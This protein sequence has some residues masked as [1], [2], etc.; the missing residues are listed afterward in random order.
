MSS[1]DA[2]TRVV[3]R[4]K[5]RVGI[6][7]MP[8]VAHIRSAGQFSDEVTPEIRRQ[9]SAQHGVLINDETFCSLP[10][11]LREE[12]HAFHDVVWKTF[13]P[14]LSGI[15]KANRARELAA[16]AER[17]RDRPSRWWP[18]A[19]EFREVAVRDDGSLWN[20]NGYADADVR[21]A[22][23]KAE[24]RLAE[25]KQ[26]S[27]QRG[28]EKRAK[29]REQRI[30]AAAEAIRKGAGIGHRLNCYCCRKALTDPASI[31]RGIGPECWEHV[32]KAVEGRL[33]EDL[34]HA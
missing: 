17:T 18:Q 11:A 20:P 28:V 10:E 16:Q 2:G 12:F 19:G 8:P 27:I 6:Y 25:R 29:R 5:I 31:E 3:V 9:M 23:A 15:Y 1:S 21:A 4:S 22:I 32:L 13:W 26:E 7:T 30:W 14:I 34:C 33:P 24:A